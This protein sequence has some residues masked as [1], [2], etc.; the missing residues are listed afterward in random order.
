MNFR[1]IGKFCLLLVIIGF[2]MPMACDQNAFQ[3]SDK[4]MV[5]TEGVVAIYVAF[6]LSIIGV[7][8]GIILLMK[9]G[10]P[11]FADWAI[12]LIVSG[13]VIVMF[14]YVGYGQGYQKYFQSGTY[15]ALIG[16]I[17]TLVAQIISAIKKET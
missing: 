17:V 16:S 9:K 5:K 7:I 8:I 6:I 12:T 14:I 2:F 15:M 4:G 11:I 3:L 1:T 10:V 13:I